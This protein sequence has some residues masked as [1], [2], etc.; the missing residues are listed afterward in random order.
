MRRKRD[1]R[2]MTRTKEGRTWFSRVD[3]S[4][5][6]FR[7]ISPAGYPIGYVGVSQRVWPETWVYTPSGG[8]GPITIETLRDIVA[9]IDRLEAT[10]NG[11]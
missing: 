4:S 11:K 8:L 2:D 10:D 9:F 3:V 5:P 6:L 1:P 7:V